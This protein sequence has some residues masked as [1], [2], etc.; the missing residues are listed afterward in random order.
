MEMA[1]AR[2]WSLSRSLPKPFSAQAELV[3]GD[4][5]ISRRGECRAEPHLG[6]DPIRLVPPEPR[7]PF[8]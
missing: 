5:P 4:D 2:S 6:F 1:A 7:L 8:Q 3:V